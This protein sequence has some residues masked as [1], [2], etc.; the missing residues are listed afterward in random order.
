MPI[1]LNGTTG[2]VGPDGSA[3]SPAIQ[4]NDSNTGVFFPAADTVAV[5]TGGTEVMRL[6]G[7]GNLQFN[8]GYG[9]V[10][11]AYGCRAWVNFNGTGTIAIRASGGVSSI[12]DNSAANYTVNFTTAM[13]DANYALASSMGPASNTPEF[14]GIN[15]A[16][17]SSCVV[18]SGGIINQYAGG[19][20]AN[21]GLAFFR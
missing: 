16:T 21:I 15:S 7:T 3:A 14:F 13:P 4:G 10:A 2:I 8:S 19:D 17:T 18:G 9:S 1:T 11:T 20:K 5:A 6:N 12:T